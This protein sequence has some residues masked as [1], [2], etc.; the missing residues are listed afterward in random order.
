L[1]DCANLVFF[2]DAFGNYFYK[3][4]NR[5]QGYSF[6]PYWKK[7]KSIHDHNGNLIYHQQHS[8]EYLSH[9]TCA[10][11]VVKCPRCGHYGL[12]MDSFSL[13]AAGFNGIKAGDPDDLNK[14]ECGSCAA[15]LDWD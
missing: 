2:Q 8:L 12:I 7:I 10:N 13:L 9:R 11:P 15:R 5:S 1:R 3:A 4:P 14:Q 6:D